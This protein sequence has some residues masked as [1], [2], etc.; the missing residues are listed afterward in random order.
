MK[1]MN[2]IKWSLCPTLSRKKLQKFFLIL[3]LLYK[4][5]KILC[6]VS[7]LNATKDIDATKDISG[8]TEV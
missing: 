7:G 1:K 4:Y 8:T 3:L 2:Y 5:G 6:Q